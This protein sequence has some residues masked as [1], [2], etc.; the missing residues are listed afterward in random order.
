M[1]DI[2]SL[3][4]YRLGQ[5]EETLLDL[6]LFPYL[7]RNSSKQERLISDI[8]KFF[9][10]HLMTDRRETI[11]N[12]LRYQSKKLQSMSNLQKN[13]CRLSR[14]SLKNPPREIYL[15]IRLFI[16]SRLTP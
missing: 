11:K 6:E 3:F 10:I 5:A 12:W 4:T 15:L 9:M 13:F 1:T 14:L 8:R 16:I 7:I 2:E